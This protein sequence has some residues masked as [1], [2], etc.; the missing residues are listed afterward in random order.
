M[1]MP[2]YS[3]VT[4]VANPE[5]SALLLVGVLYRDSLLFARREIRPKRTS[6]DNRINRPHGYHSL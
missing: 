5:I 6:D 4:T 3:I 1:G 2:I